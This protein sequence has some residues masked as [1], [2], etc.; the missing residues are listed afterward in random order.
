VFNCLEEPY[1][2]LPVLWIL[3]L[4]RVRELAN[5]SLHVEGYSLVIRLKLQENA[6]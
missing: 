5:T 1:D 2:L 6:C 3:S 4:V